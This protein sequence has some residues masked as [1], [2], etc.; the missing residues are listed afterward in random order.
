M[1][2]FYKEVSVAGAGPFAIHL[3]GREVKTPRRATLSLP[4]RGLAEAVADEW[5]TQGEEVKPAAMPLTKLANTAIDR[6]AG[7]EPAVI[8][9]IMA[10]SNDLL[11]Y[12]VSAPPDLVMRQEIA[13]NPLIDWAAGRYGAQL[14]TQVGITHFPQPEEAIAALRRAVEAFDPFALAALHNAATIL[15]SLVLTLAL[16]EGRLDAEA[17]FVLAHQDERYQAER[18]GEDHESVLRARALAAELAAVER[19]I[20][21]AKG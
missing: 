4:T 13:W 2:R 19:F 21:L 16:A 7:R 8:D 9:K 1:K 6:V 11:C 18:W 17:A 10:Y 14:T 5:R 3:D 15:N 20:R 12:R